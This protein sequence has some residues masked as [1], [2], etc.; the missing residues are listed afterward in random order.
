[1]KKLPKVL[2]HS[3]GFTNSGSL[4]RESETLPPKY[5]TQNVESNYLLMMRGWGLSQSKSIKNSQFIQL[6]P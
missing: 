3:T 6:L 2:H 1:M 5:S 4:S